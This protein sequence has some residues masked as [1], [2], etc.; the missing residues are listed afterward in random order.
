[1]GCTTSTNN[2]KTSETVCNTNI[3]RSSAGR[4][5]N[6]PEIESDLNVPQINFIKE[7]EVEGVMPVSELGVYHGRNR[8][9]LLQLKRDATL[10]SKK[11]SPFSEKFCTN[12]RKVT[13]PGN[14]SV[15]DLTA[16]QCDD[17][18]H[19]PQFALELSA[20]ATVRLRLDVKEWIE[21]NN[22]EMEADGVYLAIFRQGDCH[23]VTRLRT[24]RTEDRI[25]YEWR[26]TQSLA[27]ITV[28]LDASCSYIVTASPF[29]E[30]RNVREGSFELL[31][32]L[33]DGN[34][35]EAVMSVW[36]MPPVRRCNAQGKGAVRL[37][38]AHEHLLTKHKAE[39]EP[40]P[41]SLFAHLLLDTCPVDEVT[42]LLL[43]SGDDSF[44]ID[45]EFPPAEI[46]LNKEP[47]NSRTVEAKG[48][49]ARFHEVCPAPQLYNGAVNPDAVIQGQIGNC[50][51]I[52]CFAALGLVPEVA[53]EL[54][55]PPFYNPKGIYAVRF[56]D[57]GWRRECKWRWIVIDD[58]IPVN[59]QCQPMFARSR[60]GNELWMMILEKAFAKLIGCY[61][62]L[63]GS[64]YSNIHKRF[65]ALGTR[66][67]LLTFFNPVLS[68][69]ESNNYFFHPYVFLCFAFVSHTT[70]IRNA[71]RRKSIYL[72][73]TRTNGPG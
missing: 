4:L 42:S 66:E 23:P 54:I 36:Y 34:E 20:P 25:S 31:F 71:D 53:E 21:S 12:G 57:C 9:D 14:W 2:T 29:P 33:C 1:M 43:K 27:T 30:S 50:W 52:S 13:C 24:A 56:W 16:G 46:S 65:V 62:Y 47:G 3:D 15:K 44:F 38:G 22:E 10:N 55:Y 59:D 5:A 45:A 51:L 72:E 69:C 35:E 19:T 60:S 73:P 58:W 49:W 6:E 11:A 41:T 61:Q 26:P 18:Q 32:E 39:I 8:R 48:G 63:V 70:G 67:V 68:T 40:D 17:V 28:P 37:D 64:L 7:P